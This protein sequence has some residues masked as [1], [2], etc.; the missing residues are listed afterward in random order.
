MDADSSNRIPLCHNSEAAPI[1]SPTLQVLAKISTAR[2]PS[3]PPNVLG[4]LVSYAVLAGYSGA[5]QG[6]CLP[7]FRHDPDYPYVW[8]T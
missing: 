1:C 4:N 7:I 6:F 5:F 8:I 3:K 2:V